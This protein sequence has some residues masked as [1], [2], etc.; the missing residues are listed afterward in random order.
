MRVAVE[1]TMES[2]TL[3]LDVWDQCTEEIITMLKWNLWVR[4]PA[5]I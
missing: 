4:P 3:P 2:G 1:H 5:A